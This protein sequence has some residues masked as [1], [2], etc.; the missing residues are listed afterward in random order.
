VSRRE[1]CRGEKR[2]EIFCEI[3]KVI[4]QGHGREVKALFGVDRS[5]SVVE[6]SFSPFL[7]WCDKL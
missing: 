4:L 5:V 3:W 2:G 1:N 7:F 6:Y